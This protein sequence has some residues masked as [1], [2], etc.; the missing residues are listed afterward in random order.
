MY[1]GDA[2]ISVTRKLCLS[3]VRQKIAPG[4]STNEEG[5]GGK[6]AEGAVVSCR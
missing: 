4:L 2:R 5:G 1:I 6:G 3:Q